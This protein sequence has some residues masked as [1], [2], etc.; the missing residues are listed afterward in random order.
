MNL[1]YVYIYEIPTLEAGM[2]GNLNDTV[3]CL[4]DV[5]WDLGPRVIQI[6]ITD[7]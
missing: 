3:K 7:D 4:S 6:V 2:E 1:D 5:G